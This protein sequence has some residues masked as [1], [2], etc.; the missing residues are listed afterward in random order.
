MY[1]AHTEEQHDFRASLRR[2]LSDRLPHVEMPALLSDPNLGTSFWEPM[3][4]QL[5]LQGLHVPEQHGGSGFGMV[6]LALVLEEAGR[7]LLPE[8]FLATLIGVTALGVGDQ[9]DDVAATILSEVAAGK[10]VLTLATSDDEG[11]PVRAERETDGR[12]RL[13]GTK[14]HVVAGQL[15][16]TFLVLGFS[17]TEEALFAVDSAAA[18]ID[19][20]RS[21]DVGRPQATVHFHSAEAALISGC[22]GVADELHLIGA[23]LMAAEQTGGAGRCLDIAV[24]HAKI[25][26]QFGRPIGM[27][28]GVKHLC[29]NMLVEHESAR[30]ALMYAAW[31][32]DNDA[33][34]RVVAVAAA[35]AAASDAYWGTARCCIQVLGGIGFTEEHPAQL[36]FKRAMV[37]AQLYGSAESHRERIATH[38]APITGG[39]A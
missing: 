13:S 19:P 24:E 28:Q 32:W 20:V 36:H 16:D 18:H 10:R 14:I 5:G 22:D 3:A 39:R 37:S 33:D 23:L 11:D 27:F 30:T 15:A 31:A 7:A 35:K 2:F 17:G 29:A 21:L 34:D 9:D 8:P 25:R 4:Q 6:E 38:L 26:T 12:W 1:F